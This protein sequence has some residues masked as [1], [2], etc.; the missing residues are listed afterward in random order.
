MTKKV[1]VT[2]STKGIGKAVAEKFHNQGWNVCLNGRN[3]IRVNEL[4]TNL[5]QLREH[6]AIG[7]DSDFDS[8]QKN[9]I[10]RNFISKEWG[11]LDCIIF[12]IGSGSGT[13]GIDSTFQENLALLS[14][15]FMNTIKCFNSLYP[16]L[17]KSDYASI[18]IIGSIAQKVNVNA[19][20]AYSYSKRALNMFGKAQALNLAKHKI[21]VNII[22]PGHILTLDGVWDRKQKES[23]QLFDNFVAENIPVGRIG[24]VNDIA[25]TIFSLANEKSG[26]FLT[27]SNLNLDGGTS[28]KY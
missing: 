27:G 7:I 26:N 9:E 1:L 17:E 2:G 3:P 25:G 18:F 11:S 8:V 10:V 6:S 12:N 20:I 16:L 21:S 4:T 5:N 15:N 19:P 14:I 24:Q 28:L 13:K 23:S 22:N